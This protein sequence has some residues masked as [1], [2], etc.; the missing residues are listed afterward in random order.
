MFFYP[1]FSVCPAL[2][3]NANSRLLREFNDHL[4]TKEGM[5]KVRICQNILLITS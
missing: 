5:R 2:G 4:H 1:I 3:Y